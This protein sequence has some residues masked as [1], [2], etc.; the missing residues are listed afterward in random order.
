MMSTEPHTANRKFYDRISRA[1]DLIAET[2]EHEAREAG[3][4]LL[5][6]S[7]GESVLE[8][9]FGTGNS[10]VNMAEA[11]GTSG[12]VCGIDVSS[13]ML[14]VAQARIAESRLSDRVD[15][16]TGDARELPY[17]DKSFAAAFASFTLELFPLEDIPMVLAEVHRVLEEGGRFGVVSM[18][19][20]EQDQH[21]SL[22][23]KTYIWMHRHFP[24]IVDCRPID[25]AQCLRDAGFSIQD[26]ITMD[27]W[28]MP[29][30]AV[31]GVKA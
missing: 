27:I 1:Y 2:D 6:L 8:I 14:E 11:V 23:E 7:P 19:K 22:L 31:V 28:T 9:G 13:G 20:V 26:E 17:D 16:R 15:L 4:R 24:H 29:V 3:E 10:V 25:P 21:A 5:K 30:K 18:A 12:K